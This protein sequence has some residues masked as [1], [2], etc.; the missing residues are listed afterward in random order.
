MA[1]AVAGEPEH[2]VQVVVLVRGGQH[3][4]LGRDVVEVDLPLQPVF[5][6]ADPDRLTQVMLNLVSNAAKYNRTGTL[7]R[8]A[9][10]TRGRDIRVEVE[11]DGEGVIS[12]EVSRLF[13]P[14]D[15][16]GQQNRAKVDG[17]GLGLPLTKAMVDANRAQFAISSTP[18]AA[19]WQSSLP[20]LFGAP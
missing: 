6:C 17:T 9:C 20:C 8:L 4:L 3:G 14:F 10:Q 12:T 2:L 19:P 16:L 7:V 11:D 1:G 15:R 5:V 18:S 13:T